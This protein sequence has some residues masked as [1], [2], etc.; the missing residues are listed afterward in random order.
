MGHSSEQNSIMYPYYYDRKFDR[1]CKM[2]YDDDINGIGQHYGKVERFRFGPQCA[3]GRRPTER[4][5]RISERPRETTPRTRPTAAR[6]RYTPTHRYETTEAPKPNECNTTFD[7]IAILRNELMAFKGKWMWR[8][9]RSERDGKFH[10]L[11]GSQPSQLSRM[12][13]DLESFDRIDAVFETK[14]GNFVFFIGRRVY[15]FATNTLVRIRDI[16]DMGFG[17]NVQK[18]DAIVRYGESNKTFV[19]SGEKYWR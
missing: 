11:P 8:M 3:D 4:P 6:P 19:F 15:T 14:D 16:R 17:E 12:W 10:L 18:I 9:R 2:L 13:R 5:Y 1:K 7:A